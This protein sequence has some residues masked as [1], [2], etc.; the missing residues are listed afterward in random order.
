VHSL[1]VSVETIMDYKLEIL[2]AGLV[3]QIIIHDR[4][5]RNEQARLCKS[6]VFGVVSPLLD[7]LELQHEL[8][9]T[10]DGSVRWIRLLMHCE[11]C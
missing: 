4:I 8:K 11:P 2:L 10:I 7:V 3:L 1:F 6:T 5:S 9:A